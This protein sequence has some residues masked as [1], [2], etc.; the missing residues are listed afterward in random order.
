MRVALRVSCSNEHCCWDR[1]CEFALV[2][3]TPELAALALRRITAL[4]AQKSGDP[5]IDET[6]YW[7]SGAECYFSPWGNSSDAGAEA[8]AACLAAAGRLCEG[9]G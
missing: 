5:D 9:Q 8:E 2:E 1:G 7:A 3:V 4:R 6:Y